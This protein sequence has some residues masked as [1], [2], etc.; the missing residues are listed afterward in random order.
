MKVNDLIKNLQ[1]IITNNPKVGEWDIV[2]PVKNTENKLGSRA[3]VDVVG[4]SQGFDWNSGRVFIS[5]DAV[6][7]KSNK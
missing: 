7:Q 5:T 6:V 2:V 3:S 1:L 4:I